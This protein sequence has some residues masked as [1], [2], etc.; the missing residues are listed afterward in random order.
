MI[1]LTTDIPRQKILDSEKTQEWAEKT[2][3]AYVGLSR[4]NQSHFSED[5]LESLYKYYAGEI[6]DEDY[7]HVTKPFDSKKRNV[8][9][10]LHNYNILKSTIDILLGE[11]SKRSHE[12]TVVN[13]NPEAISAK[14]EAKKKFLKDTAINLYLSELQKQGFPVDDVEQV[15]KMEDLDQI[16]ESSYTDRKSIAGQQ[17]MNYQYRN[18]EMKDKFIEGFKHFLISGVVTSYRGVNHDEVEYDILNPLDVDGDKDPDIEFYEDGDWAIMRKMSYP[19]SVIDYYFEDLNE[20]QIDRLENPRGEFSDDFISRKGAANSFLSQSQNSYQRR[21]RSIEVVRCFWKARKKIG[22]LTY[23]DE[24]GIE[25]EDIVDEG[26]QPGIDEEVKWEWIN[27]VWEGHRIDGDIFVRC[28]PLETERRNLDNPSKCKLP[29]NGRKYSDI[30][31][32]SISLLMLGIPY[33]LSFNIYKYK[34]DLAVAKSKDIIAQFDINAIPKKWKPEDF[35]YWIDNTGIAWVDYNKEDVKFSPQHQA[36]IDLTMK[37]IASYIELLESIITEWERISGVNAQRAGIIGQYEGKATSQQAI[38]QS[39]YVTED[40][41]RRFQ[42]F[43]QRDLQATMDYSKYA[44]K[45]GKKAQY[46]TDDGS[47]S[48]IDIDGEEFM[49]SEFGIFVSNQA[50]DLEKLE[51]IKQ[52]VQPMIQNG[53][54][55]SVVATIIASENFSDIKEKIEKAEKMSAQQQE[56]IRELELQEEQ[57]KRDHELHLQDREDVRKVMDNETKIIVADKNNEAKKEVARINDRED[58]D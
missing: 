8:P 13:T 10:K 52:M 29:I 57:A 26:Y 47:I 35:M 5:F 21:E 44:F 58:N 7:T 24:M 53:T 40:L 37:T 41:F 12:F 51:M 22:F 19:S 42:R 3:N 34:L 46:I 55:A 27:E 39:S 16:F 4:F 28:R 31:S 38:V 6:D 20:D 1:T 15:P 30:N 17:A 18:L 43:E 49:E 54:P 48:Q 56:Q 50:K 25:Q 11:K 2:V 9:A 32:G 14:K 23:T 33:Q 36:A 45:N